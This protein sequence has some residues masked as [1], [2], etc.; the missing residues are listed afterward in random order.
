MSNLQS[1]RPATLVES[2]AQILARGYRRA[3]L[4][5]RGKSS[6]GDA[7]EN[8]QRP[9]AVSPNQSVHGG[10]TSPEGDPDHCQGNKP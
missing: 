2:V 5:Q 8:F 3:M 4:R 10:R 7:P 6:V 1:S 9:L